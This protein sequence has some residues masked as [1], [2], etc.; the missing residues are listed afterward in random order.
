MEEKSDYTNKPLDE[1]SNFCDKKMVCKE[2]SVKNMIKNDDNIV[3]NKD[4]LCL[5]EDDTNQEILEKIAYQIYKTTEEKFY[6]SEIFAFYTTN[7]IELNEDSEEYSNLHP[8]G[9]DYSSKKIDKTDDKLSLL[10]AN[11]ISNDLIDNSFVN[12]EGI[13]ILNDYEDK[14]D[15]LF[16]NNYHIRHKINKNIYYFTL[17]DLLEK[18]KTLTKKSE[19]M[20]KKI[21]Y[22]I[23]NKYFPN[24]KDIRYMNYYDSFGDLRDS[25]FDEI[26]KYIKNHEPV[27][28]KFRKKNTV[29]C[30][31]NIDL[32]KFYNSEQNDNRLRIINMFCNTECKDYNDLGRIHFTQLK[33]G[34]DSDKYY[35]LL[36][37]QLKYEN[38]ESGNLTIDK[39]KY[40]TKGI[41]VVNETGFEYF[42]KLDSFVIHFYF[43][44]LTE[45]SEEERY[46]TLVF[47]LSGKVECII[48]FNLTNGQLIKVINAC[49]AWIDHF[50]INNEYSE[51][52]QDIHKFDPQ[53]LNSLSDTTDI[54]YFDC[55]MSLSLMNGKKLKGY[56]SKGF[57]ETIKQ[58]SD[59]FRIESVDKK[60]DGVL[61]RYKKVD[62]YHSQKNI[63]YIITKLKNPETD[64]LSNEEVKEYL[65]D[66]L[67]FS[68]HL[69]K[70]SLK[71]WEDFYNSHKEKGIN[72]YN[73]VYPELGPS[74]KVVPSGT[75]LSF[76]IK[77]VKSISEITQLIIYSKRIVNFYKNNSFIKNVKYTKDFNHKLI[78]D[79]IIFEEV[80][81]EVEEKAEEEEK[82]VV[83][84]EA[85]EV[86]K[87][88]EEKEEEE[89]EEGEEDSD[90]DSDSY[91]EDNLDDMDF[92][93]STDESF[94]GGKKKKPKDED[95]PDKYALNK[96]KFYNPEVYNKDALRKVQRPRHPIVITDE[97][98]DRILEDEEYS[99]RKSFT[100]IIKSKDCD[101]LGSG[102]YDYYP[103]KNGSP[104]YYI[105]PKFFDIRKR[106][107][108]NERSI[109]GS[110]IKMLKSE[111]SKLKEIKEIKNKV[112]KIKTKIEMQLTEDFGF[113]LKVA[114]E[115][116]DEF[117]N[118]NGENHFVKLITNFKDTTNKSIIIV[119][120]TL[121][122][123][124]E[125]NVGDFGNDIERRR[126][127][128][129]Y[130]NVAPSKSGTK[131][132]YTPSIYQYKKNKDYESEWEKW[133]GKKSE[134]NFKC[135]NPTKKID[136]G[137]KHTKYTTN[138]VK[139]NVL[140]L[141]KDQFGVLSP[142]INKLMNNL[143]TDDNI[144]DESRT[145]P[146][147][148]RVG[149]DENNKIP[150]IIKAYARSLK[151]MADEG[152][153]GF[154]TIS[155]PEKFK[156]SLINF[157]N[158][159]DSGKG[160][161]YEQSF[162]RYILLGDTITNKYIGE[163]DEELISDFKSVSK[164][165]FSKDKRKAYE[166]VK[167]INDIVGIKKFKNEFIIRLNLYSSQKNYV[168]KLENNS[169]KG[170]DILPLI[171][172]YFVN[173]QKKIHTIIFYNPYIRKE[174]VDLANRTDNIYI[175]Q[176][177]AYNVRSNFDSDRGRKLIFLYLQQDIYQPILLLEKDNENN[178]DKLSSVTDDSLMNVIGQ[179]NVSDL[180][181][182]KDFENN[183]N[184]AILGAVGKDSK[185]VRSDLSLIYFTFKNNKDLDITL[186]SLYVNTSN[187]VSH[188]IMTTEG[189]KTLYIIPFVVDK[190][191]YFSNPFNF[192]FDLNKYINDKNYASIKDYESLFKKI[193]K[194]DEGNAYTEFL[195]GFK[196]SGVSV[197]DE[198]KI[199]TL[200][201]ENGSFIP[202]N[203]KEEYGGKYTKYNIISNELIL[204][205]EELSLNTIPQTNMLEEYDAL[206]I[207]KL[208]DEFKYNST[209]Y[210]YIL[211]NDYPHESKH[212]IEQSKGGQRISENNVYKFI[213]GGNKEIYLKSLY[214]EIT[215]YDLTGEILTKEFKDGS[216]P[217]YYI[218]IKQKLIHHLLG[219]LKCEKVTSDKRA[220]LF[221]F[222][223][224]G[225]SK[226]YKDLQYD[227]IISVE[228]IVEKLQDLLDN[229]KNLYKFIDLLIANSDND[230]E[231]FQELLQPRITASQLKECITDN[232]LLFTRKDILEKD[233]L[234][235]YIQ[236]QMQ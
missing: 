168:K 127:K 65:M 55:R 67:H 136:V 49:N 14:F 135:D 179:K 123:I 180:F 69:A 153:D 70:E 22:G 35:R 125:K 187:E 134:L 12:D 176:D 1:K 96:L 105:S 181:Y 158:G 83:K 37:D 150:P 164:S 26:V 4:T 171:K 44:K 223:K 162:K 100:N 146:Y 99:G 177:Y 222:F 46:I 57:I 73:N 154:D 47:N 209:M 39:I 108:V 152:I 224:G 194:K 195:K 231:T 21:F 128:Y 88:V 170:E 188:F 141:F 178:K 80:A 68:S 11:N 211:K 133:K 205:V 110:R 173:A 193:K 175:I 56:T 36:K 38:N 199:T 29:E 87:E 182:Y 75:K 129:F 116:Y 107:S 172:A 214:P 31:M 40:W 42:Y 7:G 97:E 132:F 9:F 124:T 113:S 138:I 103:P 202:L 76:V 230:L 117:H 185:S 229:D 71:N 192:S 84:E 159:I 102:M 94:G 86:A 201:L 16:G 66:N 114:K 169:M 160:F 2:Y 77:N 109:Y 236:Y 89:E 140:N 121:K 78:K 131:T 183:K 20:D 216:T 143:E 203:G 27:F 235:D 207:K 206:E 126:Q 10:I 220:E 74:V 51:I 41:N 93:D 156:D 232:E 28:E 234:N 112:Q 3:F 208:D 52:D 60:T 98:L 30:D 142:Q 48:D 23:V 120:H 58:L 217:M 149:V 85:E 215:T 95:K 233:S 210:Y 24:I 53:F 219:I 92:N 118:Y 226:F 139:D 59:Y 218:T 165:V 50:N 144:R 198:N 43:D 189:G 61:L 81:K 111:F 91:S 15:C 5:I 167:N 19:L 130:V 174:G 32:L 122:E 145:D 137:V 33:L 25:K 62:N 196:I 13:P 148:I 17:K 163:I 190:M 6:S 147:F 82:K 186:V 204:D 166:R 191:S 157:I 90:S 225:D 72:I 106:V 54:D 151:V 200:F 227:G 79:N 64:N 197:N 221:T 45:V 104:L 18:L 63:I 212:F 34:K 213:K 101:D 161:N 228:T 119:P 155:T 184:N 8:I 115:V